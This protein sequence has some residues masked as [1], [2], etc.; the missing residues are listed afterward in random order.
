M[1]GLYL[2]TGG[3]GFVGAAVVRQLLA[4]KRRVRVLDNQFRGSA[5]R[6]AD[7]SGRFEFVEADV[8]DGKAVEAAAHGADS[9]L[10]LAFIN[11]TEHF[12]SQPSLVL[13]VGVRGMVNVLEACRRQRV[14]ELLVVSSSEVYHLAPKIPTDEKAPLCIPDPLNPRYSYSAGKII[15]EMMALHADCLDRAM[16]VRPHNIYGPAMGFEHVIPQFVLRMKELCE[17]KKSGAVKF[18]IQGSGDETRAFMY[19]EDFARAMLTVLERGRHREIYHVGTMEEVRI[20]HLARLIGLQ[21][22]RKIEVLAGPLQAGGTPRRCPDT[23]KL[24]ALGFKPK[25]RLKRGLAKAVEWY[26]AN[27]HLAPQSAG[28]VPRVAK[29]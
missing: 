15:S 16:I 26:R 19:V 23:G 3:C 2:V 27:A 5:D 9:I 20:G 4:A 10:H 7:L 6:L 28:G 25:F 14:R 1:A 21:F 29:L 17:R 18:P 11:G 12:Y 24:A 13:D 22:R 8:R